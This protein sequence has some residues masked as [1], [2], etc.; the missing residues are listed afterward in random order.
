MVND[1]AD[2]E[3]VTLR[4]AA[5]AAGL[6]SLVV[7]PL[8]IGGR[9]VAL[10]TLYSEQAGVFDEDEMK[11]LTQMADD[12][13]LALDH[14]Q[15]TEKLDFLACYDPLTGLAN[16]S[17][18]LDRVTQY[19]HSASANE[20]KLVLVLID[21]ERFG[22]VNDTFGRSVGDALLK[23]VSAWM[24][25]TIGD[26]NLLAR[27]DADHF[28][29]VMPEIQSEEAAARY[30]EHSKKDFLDE[31]FI[32]NGSILRLGSKVGLAM[33][34][35]DGADAETLFSHA[36]AA[37]KKAKGSGEPYVFY[38]QKMTDMVAGKLA[39]ENRLIHALENDEFVLHYQ[40]KV[41]LPTHRISGVEALIRW[42]DPHGGM[43][44]PG[45]FI[46]MLEET[47][48][49]RQV[50]R[51]ALLT[52]LRDVRR[53]RR[54]GADHLRVAVNVSS[55]QLRDPAFVADVERI[56]EA[57]G[58]SARDLELEITESMIMQ[59]VANGIVALNALRA[60]GVTVA[61]DDFGTGYSSLGYLSKL[62]IDTIKIDRTFVSGMTV[63]SEGLA[64]V[65][66]IIAL[67]HAMKLKVVAEGVE[68][69][70]QSR[71]LRL[72]GCDEMQGYL[73]CRPIPCDLLDAMF[74]TDEPTPPTP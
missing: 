38:T 68:T 44:A 20:R 24:T 34:P 50:G 9:P 53:W 66:T 55:M 43:V 1:I 32:V 16:R 4:E 71:L 58:G 62:P 31:P 57:S 30:L 39:L 69:E 28:A 26:A 21:I 74:A 46:P 41:D 10:F 13:S 2:D 19:M 15:K 3:R 33:F 14:I 23:H 18:F 7:L 17:L 48:L 40:P 73:F 64:L 70:D 56:I 72:L 63:S 11:L 67:A 35:E 54:P 8:S 47:G 36:E 49:I 65:S 12:L 51:W 45:E 29:I 60:L 22:S 42:N 27:I 37:L 5:L 52:A 6:R 61:I 25:R 59:D